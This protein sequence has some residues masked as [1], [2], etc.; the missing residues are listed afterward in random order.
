MATLTH[1][2]AQDLLAAFKQGWERRAPD[3][4][5]ELFERDA[6][7]RPQPFAEPLQGVNAIRALWNDLA[8]TQAN[9]EF[10]AER[11]W[12][13]GATVLASWHA[14][15]TARATSERIRVRGFMT[16]ELSESSPP[17]V[18]RLKQWPIERVVGTDST[19]VVQ[20]ERDDIGF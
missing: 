15:Y 16:M 14:A 19:Y 3:L 20:E 4:I 1:G 8:S 5:V 6:E 11:I 2:D 10:D 18:V 9:V 17:R 13:S 12:V 7:Y